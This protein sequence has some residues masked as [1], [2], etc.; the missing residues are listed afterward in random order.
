MNNQL[1]GFVF[2][3]IDQLEEEEDLRLADPDPKKGRIFRIFRF[4]YQIRISV[5]FQLSANLRRISIPIDRFIAP[6]P[7]H[8]PYN[9]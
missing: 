3:L 5:D 8:N 6:S 2:L 4:G 7:T 1:I 9:F